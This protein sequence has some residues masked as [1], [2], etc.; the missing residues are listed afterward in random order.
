[1]ETNRVGVELSSLA[2]KI[3]DISL[4]VALALPSQKGAPSA[5]HDSVGVLLPPVASLKKSH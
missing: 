1:M 3:K 2:G 5:L 4:A